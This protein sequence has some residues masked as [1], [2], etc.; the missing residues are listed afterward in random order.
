[1]L[2]CNDVCSVA[3]Y[4]TEFCE[5]SAGF[6]ARIRSAAPEQLERGGTA[7]LGLRASPNGKKAG[8]ICLDSPDRRR[9]PPAA[10]N[11]LHFL[12]ST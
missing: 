9:G 8:E 10:R 6:L 11:A 3:P 12:S 5:E 4:C 1:M 2:T 7:M